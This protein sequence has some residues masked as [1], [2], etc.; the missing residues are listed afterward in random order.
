M[1]FVKS[2]ARGQHLAANGRLIRIDSLRYILY[3]AL[4]RIN[5]MMMMMMS[6]TAQEIRN[7]ESRL[8]NE[9]QLFYGTECLETVSRRHDLSSLRE[10]LR[11]AASLTEMILDSKDVELLLLKDDVQNKLGNLTSDDDMFTP[12]ATASKVSLTIDREFQ[13]YEFLIFENSHE[14]YNVCS[15]LILKIKIQSEINNKRY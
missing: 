8:V 1:K 9:L 13:L 14:F 4:W 2:F 5:M 6:V 11:S 10:H 3:S 7:S 12:P 15:L